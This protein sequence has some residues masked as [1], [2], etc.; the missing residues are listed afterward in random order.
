MPFT[1]TDVEKTFVLDP[2]NPRCASV[3]A[4]LHDFIANL[5]RNQAWRIEIG[6]QIEKRSEQQNRTFHM[7]VNQ[8]AKQLAWGSAYTKEFVKGMFG[9]L[10]GDTMRGDQKV[11]LLKSTADYTKVDMMTTMKHMQDWADEN[12]ITLTIP[13]GETW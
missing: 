3:Q 10:I 6:P 8:M 1:S 9:P 11:M 4:N 7:W 2:R 12:K 5:P 13:E